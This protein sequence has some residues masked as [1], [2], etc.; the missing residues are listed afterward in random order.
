[1]VVTEG[2]C[3]ASSTPRTCSSSSGHSPLIS[4]SRGFTYA[5]DVCAVTRFAAADHN[6]Y[7]QNRFEHVA[8]SFTWAPLEPAQ[9]LIAWTAAAPSPARAGAASTSAVFHELAGIRNLNSRGFGSSI[10]F[11]KLLEA[12]IF[13]LLLVSPRQ[14]L[15]PLSQR[16]AE[17]EWLGANVKEAATRTLIPIA[18]QS[19]SRPISPFCDDRSRRT[20]SDELQAFWADRTSRS[21]FREAL[22]SSLQPLLSFLVRKSFER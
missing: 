4:R 17:C 15:S 14:L 5:S 18:R 19:F 22:R 20:G 9:L 8:L 1:M 16:D 10:A 13:G 3:S 11:L 2:T 12:G 21:N 7:G 6:R